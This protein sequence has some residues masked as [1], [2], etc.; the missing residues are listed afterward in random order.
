M[1]AVE[2]REIRHDRGGKVRTRTRWICRPCHNAHV[3]AQSRAKA[4]AEQVKEMER[5][6][7]DRAELAKLSP[8][9]KR[10]VLTRR[11]T[12]RTRRRMIETR[13]WTPTVRSRYGLTQQAYI[14]LLEKQDYKCPLC[15]KRHRYEEWASKEPAKGVHNHTGD[16][17]V[18]NYLLVV[19]H[20][21]DTGEV[22][23]LLCSDCN[24]LEGLVKKA[25]ARGVNL[26]H[27]VDYTQQ[28]E[29]REEHRDVA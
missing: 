3:K 18:H 4:T 10:R 1:E 26:Q 19:D 16:D 27:L 21:H 25:L 8:E 28:H 2:Y 24:M 12:V 20:D 9:E 15:G 14:D 5:K 22:R 7:A 6:E 23:G 11:N 13:G 29:R 17:H